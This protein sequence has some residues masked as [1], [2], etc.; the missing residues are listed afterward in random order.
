M[1]Q[2]AIRRVRWI[3]FSAPKARRMKSSTEWSSTKLNGAPRQPRACW[4]KEKRHL[5]RHSAAHP[6]HNLVIILLTQRLQPV[7]CSDAEYSLAVRYFGDVVRLIRNR[8]VGQSAAGLSPQLFLYTH[9]PPRIL[10]QW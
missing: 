5:T 1:E 9:N 7:R 3:R 6:H 2:N 8:P 4:P 10:V